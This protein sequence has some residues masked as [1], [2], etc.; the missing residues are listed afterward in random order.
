LDEST[1]VHR[2][3]SSPSASKRSHIHVIRCPSSAF[4]PSF[5]TVFTSPFHP[6]RC[7]GQVSDLSWTLWRR[8]LGCVLGALVIIRL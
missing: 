7:C 8:L 4:C 6:L 3:I 5:F 1:D 2:R